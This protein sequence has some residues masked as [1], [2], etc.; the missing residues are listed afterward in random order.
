MGQ[1]A[2]ERPTPPPK[3]RKTRSQMVS[4]AGTRI[5]AVKR[6]GGR[7]GK[8]REGKGK[9]RQRNGKGKGKE[10]KGKGGVGEGEGG[11]EGERQAVG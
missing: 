11:R 6:Q 7:E 4:Y 2:R 3:Q 9:K 8:G 1:R 10:K 5:S